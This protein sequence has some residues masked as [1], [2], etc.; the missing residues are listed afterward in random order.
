M[1]QSHNSKKKYARNRS[2][3]LDKD[4]PEQAMTTLK[5]RIVTDLRMSFT[6]DAICDLLARLSAKAREPFQAHR[7]IYHKRPCF[8]IFISFCC[9]IPDAK[10]IYAVKNGIATRTPCIRWLSKMNRARNLQC[11]WPETLPEMKFSSKLC[12]LAINTTCRPASTS[13]SLKN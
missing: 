2:T 4:L 9:N 11:D 6:H 1:T 12:P 7:C 8:P 3:S 10:E 5:H 13:C